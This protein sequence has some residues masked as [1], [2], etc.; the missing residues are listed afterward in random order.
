M[1]QPM[2]SVYGE[3]IHPIPDEPRAPTSYKW[4]VS[5]YI[6]SIIHGLKRKLVTGVVITPIS[7]V[8][9]PCL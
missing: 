6:I 3:P 5:K 7:E 4:I 9:G 1:E 2:T 8:M